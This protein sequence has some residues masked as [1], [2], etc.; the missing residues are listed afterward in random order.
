METETNFKDLQTHSTT[1][2][3]VLLEVEV[4]LLQ[5]LLPVVLGGSIANGTIT[6]INIAPN[7]TGGPKG[8]NLN[9]NSHRRTVL[10]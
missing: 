7:I 3:K 10:I 6:N 8:G 5:D 2:N 4:V 1:R 9:R